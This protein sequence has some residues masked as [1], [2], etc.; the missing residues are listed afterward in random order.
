MTSRVVTDR[1]FTIVE[2]FMMGNVL[3]D[4]SGEW[5]IPMAL[6]GEFNSRIFVGSSNITFIVF[7]TVLSFLV[8]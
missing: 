1:L 8:I 2:F 6:S 4:F 3:T 5:T 7:I